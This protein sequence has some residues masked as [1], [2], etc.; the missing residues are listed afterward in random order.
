METILRK[1][2]EWS[3]IDGEPCRILNFRPLASVSNGKVIT[4]NLTEPYALVT[5]GCEKLPQQTKGFITHRSDF[6]HL[7]LAFED[8]KINEDEEVIII[9]TQK[10]YKLKFLKYFPWILPKLR[11]MICKKGAFELMTDLNSKPGLDGIARW[12]AEKPIVEWKPEI[13]E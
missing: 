13:M 6:L 2:S 3:V 8:R 11:V 12:N 5:L 7:W 9:W 1:D 4:S 10:H